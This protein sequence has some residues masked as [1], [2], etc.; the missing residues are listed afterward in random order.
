MSNR[1]SESTQTDGWFVE[2]ESNGALWVLTK[3][4]EHPKHPFGT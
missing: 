2:K 4:T 1:E 3:G